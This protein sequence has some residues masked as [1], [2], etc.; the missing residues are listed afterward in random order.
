MA[1]MWGCKSGALQ[2]LQKD[3]LAHQWRNNYGADQDFLAKIIYPHIKHKSLIHDAIG[4]SEQG[5]DVRLFPVIREGLDFVGQC[6]DAQ[7][8]PNSYYEETLF[9]RR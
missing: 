5:L 1:G 7:D 3:W 9:Q 4:M 6:F 2:G 8:N